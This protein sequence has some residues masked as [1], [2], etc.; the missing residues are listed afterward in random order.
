MKLSAFTWKYKELLSLLW[1]FFFFGLFVF[2]CSGMIVQDQ[3]AYMN[4]SIQA[5]K[6]REEQIRANR[7]PRSRM[8]YG[9]YYPFP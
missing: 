2:M 3:E 1:G 9:R 6:E 4:R 8:R 7:K 5:Q